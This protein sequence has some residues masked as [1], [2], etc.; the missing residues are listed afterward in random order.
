M[1]AQ[2]RGKGWLGD[3]LHQTQLCPEQTT[4]RLRGG[5]GWTDM[6]WTGWTVIKNNRTSEANTLHLPVMA[7]WGW[8]GQLEVGCRP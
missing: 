8:Q 3:L 4:V 2:D 5:K 6:T 7:T 1:R